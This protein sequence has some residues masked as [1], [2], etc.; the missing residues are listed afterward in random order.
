MELT[1]LYTLTELNAWMVCVYGSM[2]YG[3][4]GRSIRRMTDIHVSLRWLMT[5]PEMYDSIVCYIIC[6]KEFW[7]G[8]I[9]AA[10]RDPTASA[11]LYVYCRP[12]MTL[13]FI[14]ARK[15]VWFNCGV[16]PLE[17]ARQ[18]FGLTVGLN[19]S[20]GLWV[21]PESQMLILWYFSH[22]WFIFSQIKAIYV[23]VYVFFTSTWGYFHSSSQSS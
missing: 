15:L 18:I 2:L 19:R 8:A 13:F 1:V 20:F 5:L 17:G 3:C 10:L 9:G 21:S 6:P 23:L 14:A 11:A 4:S 7:C 12:T 22:F 16:K